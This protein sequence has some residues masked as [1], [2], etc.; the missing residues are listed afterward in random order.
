MKLTVDDQTDASIDPHTDAETPTYILNMKALAELGRKPEVFAK[1]EDL[2]WD[3]PHISKM[4]LQAHLNPET[5]AASRRPEIID[6]TVAWLVSE[7]G[8]NPNASFIDLGC[9]PGLYCTRLARRGLEVTGL[10][11]SR[12][13]IQYAREQAN[14]EGL[15]IE[16][17]YQNYLTMDYEE[18]FDAAAIIFCDLGALSNDDRDTLLERVYRALRPGGVFVADVF[19][20][21]GR[22][23]GRAT[24]GWDAYESSFWRP[25]PHLVLTST[26]AYPE[27]NVELDQYI[28]IEEDGGTSLYR[29]WDHHYTADTLTA[30]VE[31]RGFVVEGVWGSLTGEKYDREKSEIVAVVARKPRT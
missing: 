24:A 17:K 11:Y 31:A 19:T 1:G 25:H 3:H 13:S 5:D 23:K 4:M 27:D 20:Q 30:V 29:I 28:V 8:L 22:A 21:R 15:S 26:F 9:G 6:A 14:R 18:R 7:L 16:Y 2:F 12:R 10:D